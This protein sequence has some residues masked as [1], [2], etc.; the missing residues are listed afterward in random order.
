MKDWKVKCW[1]IEKVLFLTLLCFF[2]SSS[3][4]PACGKQEIK[5]REPAVSGQYYPGDRAKLEEMLHELYKRV[6]ELE[7][8]GKVKAIISPHAGY[9]FSGQAA[10][11]GYSLLEEGTF[12]RIII[13]GPSHHAGFHGCSVPDVTHYKTPLGLVEVDTPVCKE[14]LKKEL[15]STHP[16]AH[17]LEHSI[18]V[19]LPLLQEKLT[20]FKLVPIVVGSLSKEDCGKIA[21]SLKP[22]L[23]DD[24]L[25]V[26]SSDFTHY[27]PNYG[28]MPFKED[29]RENLE[30]LDM[31]AVDSI[32]RLD[33]EEFMDYLEKTYITICGHNPIGILLNLLPADSEGNLL[34]YYTSGDIIGDYTNSVS[35]CSIV[36]THFSLTKWERKILLSLARKALENFFREGKLLEVDPVKQGYSSNLIA[37]R[38]PM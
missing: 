16:Q 22:L 3:L 31:G 25:I 2:L 26:A 23:T 24:T 6:P 29:I 9:Q 1:R 19:Q 27:G 10:A 17:K 8:A 37:R 38:G 36:F 4:V 18:E 20:K 13:L 28:Y 30:N 15:F 14:L 11:Y 21:E 34:M 33:F 5:V 12:S 35:Y 7:I 32:I